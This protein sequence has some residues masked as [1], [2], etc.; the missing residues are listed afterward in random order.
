MS[1]SETIKDDKLFETIKRAK[2]ELGFTLLLD[3]TC[4]DNLH[5]SH[6]KSCR[7]ELV[8]ILRHSHFEKTIIYKV[9]VTYPEI[10]VET[11]TPLFASADW[12]EREVYDQYGIEFRGIQCSNDY[13]II[14]NL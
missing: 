6:P 8:Y 4:I 13:S 11:L 9:E 12:A 3:I 2:E 1:N 10:G 14:M 7:F 5:K